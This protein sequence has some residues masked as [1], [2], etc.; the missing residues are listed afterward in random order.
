LISSDINI[1]PAIGFGLIL[2]ELS[3]LHN[4]TVRF[5]VS[6]CL[7]VVQQQVD[8]P[9]TIAFFPLQATLSKRLQFCFTTPCTK[10]STIK[11]LV[12]CHDKKIEEHTE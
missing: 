8:L 9:K 10:P 6:L 11:L 7:F 1:T 2:F 3:R 12:L 4:L 5:F